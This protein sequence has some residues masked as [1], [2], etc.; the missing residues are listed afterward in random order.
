MIVLTA[1]LTVEKENQA[2]LLDAVTTKLTETRCKY[3]GLLK[4]DIVMDESDRL[5][6]DY[7]L[8]EY[9]Q[10]IEVHK[11]CFAWLKQTG[12]LDEIGA[13]LT[14]PLTLNFY[15]YLQTI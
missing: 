8:I 7:F 13:M 3:P 15:N 14:K 12:F 1:T 6:T 2:T 11:E 10:S 5:V 9:W 4:V